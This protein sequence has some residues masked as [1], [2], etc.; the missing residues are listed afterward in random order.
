M[1]K[2]ITL[3]FVIIIFVGLCIFSGGNTN[4]NFNKVPN[5]ISLKEKIRITHSF[6][7]GV[8][9]LAGEINLPTLCHTLV[10]KIIITESLP[11]RITVAFNS[12]NSVPT[13]EQF[14]NP[15][16]FSVV[17]QATED[18][19]F[20]ITLDKKGVP[21]M[22]TEKESFVVENKQTAS[23]TSN[24]GN[25]IDKNAKNTNDPLGEGEI[26]SSTTS[27]TNLGSE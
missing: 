16:P 15:E 18:V 24:G 8:H 10:H 1:N 7:D 20:D 22:I 14:V 11:E 27:V 2:K 17:F 26:L 21:F 23:T 19:V 5:S 12:K 4:N 13:C 9:T 25:N 6:A 3:L